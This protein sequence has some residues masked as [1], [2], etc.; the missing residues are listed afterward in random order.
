MLTTEPQPGPAALAAHATDPVEEHIVLATDGQPAA[1]AAARWLAER[2]RSHVIDVDLVHVVARHPAGAGA[3]SG[4]DDPTARAKTSLSV[5]APSVVA[6]TRV[7]AGDVHDVLVDL[8]KAADLVVFGTRRNAAALHLLPS[9]STR[10][11]KSAWCPVVVVPE[12]WRSSVGPIVVGVEGDGSDT[13]AI[14]FAAHEAM[15][16]RRDLVLV[17]AW[18]LAPLVWPTLQVDQEGHA[19]AHGPAARLAAIADPLSER[20][21]ELSVV[22]ILEHD[23]PI[24]ALVRDARDASLLVVGTHG[25]DS[26]ERFVLGSISRGVMERPACPI[27]VIRPKPDVR[28]PAA[29]TSLSTPVAP[30][31]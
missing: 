1:S 30:P 8:T 19:T 31:N 13:T 5:T 16:L 23:A 18:Q 26:V 9:F 28:G 10:F 4:Q 27:A 21:P 3:P 14:E 29:S 15:V 17:H 12:G 2:A 24:R 25:L 6:T 20:Y 22:P 7:I 11:A